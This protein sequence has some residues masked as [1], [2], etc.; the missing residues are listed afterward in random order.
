MA[1]CFVCFA[2]AAALAAADNAG[3]EGRVV[4]ASPGPLRLA[5]VRLIPSGEYFAR[6]RSVA[7]LNG[8]FEIRDVLPGKYTLRVGLQAFRERVITEV[9]L[10]SGELKNLGD[11]RLE[12]PASSPECKFA[13]ASRGRV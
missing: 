11:V 5:L 8:E 9:E 3:V 10:S 4:D 1:R 2:L 7:N 13:A 12:L 6:Y